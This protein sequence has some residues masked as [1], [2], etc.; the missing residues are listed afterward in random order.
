MSELRW[1]VVHT[2]PRREKKVKLSCERDGFLATLPC[3]PAAHR[4]RGKTV[5]FQK[6][7]FPG[8]V[9]LQLQAEQKVRV[10]QN[11]HVARLLFVHDQELFGRQLGE[12][13]RVLDQEVE[14]Y[15]APQIG[16]GCCV[17]VRS[18]PLRGVEGWV[19]KR[20]GSSTVL[21]RLDFIGQAAAVK[22]QAD[23]LELI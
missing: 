7:L 4:Y 2:R 11:E 8:Y 16:A 20:Y 6:P 14:I 18:G 12:I 10:A 1:F 13:L 9:F 3:Y 17:K 22:L 15:L 19:E 21:L 5:T 23:E